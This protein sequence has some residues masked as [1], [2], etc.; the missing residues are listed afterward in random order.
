MLRR[1]A[2][3][4]CWAPPR[5]RSPRRK[6]VWPSR[7][8]GRGSPARPPSP[9]AP[10][11]PQWSL[12]RSSTASHDKARQMS[13]ARGIFQDLG[14]AQ[15]CLLVKGAAG[16]LQAERQPVGAEPRRDRDRRHAGEIRRNS[17]DIVQIHRDRVVGILADDEGGRWRRRGQDAIDPLERLGEV[18]RYQGAHTLRLQI[19]GVIVSGRQHVGADQHTAAD[20]SAEPG[21][22][23]QF[24]HLVEAVAFDPQAKS[25]AVIAREV[26]RGLGRCDYVI[27]RERMFG[28]RQADLDWLG[29]R[30]SKPL[31]TLLPQR[32][33]LARHPVYAIFLRE[34]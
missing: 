27:G 20:L 21:G 23:R 19:I 12:W 2:K 4:G 32:F 8:L 5:T 18:A 16:D 9:T 22:A 15:Y 31:D 25:H 14:D 1:P 6:T 34:A 24:V 33:D 3:P 26:R 10:C 7:S 28:H 29:A 13:E 17:E 11:G 30:R